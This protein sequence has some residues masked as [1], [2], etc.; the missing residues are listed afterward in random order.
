MLPAAIPSAVDPHSVDAEPGPAG[1]AKPRKRGRLRRA[2][3]AGPG[4]A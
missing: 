4:S 3:P 1:K 2:L